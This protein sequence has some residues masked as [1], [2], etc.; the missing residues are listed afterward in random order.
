MKQ[1]HRIT[2]VN[3]R[4]LRGVCGKCGEVKVRWCNNRFRC[5]TQDKEY[6]QLKRNWKPRD[7]S[8][9][10]YLL[11]A[12]NGLTKIGVSKNVT[13]RLNA[14]QKISP[15]Q[16]DLI[17]FKSFE[18][19]YRIENQ[20]HSLF[21]C[22]RIRNEWFKLSNEDIILI[23]TQYLRWTSLLGVKPIGLHPEGCPSAFQS[24]TNNHCNLVTRL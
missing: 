9:S 5:R 15:C 14:I 17:C 16:I 6:K 7:N 11:S 21:E 22:Q 12:D 1:L 2:N 19:A 8:G 10:V 24:Y 4:T 13:Q 3:E 20:L 18:D 23:R